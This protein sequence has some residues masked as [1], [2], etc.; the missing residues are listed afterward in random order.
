M[1]ARMVFLS[2]GKYR[3]TSNSFISNCRSTEILL[4]IILGL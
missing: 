1:P 2:F 4:Q 3:L